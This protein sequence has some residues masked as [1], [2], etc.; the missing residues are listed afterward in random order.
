[1]P[2]RFLF[3]GIFIFDSHDSVPDHSDNEIKVW[4]KSLEEMSIE[5]E[6]GYYDQ[7]C[8]RVSFLVLY[9]ALRSHESFEDA[10]YTLKSDLAEIIQRNSDLIF[11]TR[12][13]YERSEAMFAGYNQ[14]LIRNL[15]QP[16]EMQSLSI[17][18]RSALFAYVRKTARKEGVPIRRVYRQ[19]VDVLERCESKKIENKARATVR[20]CYDVI[21]RCHA[22]TVLAQQ[23]REN[24][25]AAPEESKQEM[26]VLSL[27]AVSVEQV[28]HTSPLSG[29][30]SAF[31]KFQKP[32][33]SPVSHAVLG[34]NQNQINCLT[35]STTDS[36]LKATAT[37]FQ[38]GKSSQPWYSSQNR[39]N[40]EPAPAYVRH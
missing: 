7:L 2:E 6:A 39:E 18:G 8:S 34:S 33:D 20:S 28:Q 5:E 25:V 37:E 23:R 16:E 3:H 22:K 14:F 26:P 35:L 29:G 27:S 13:Q 15:C 32:A 19:M 30:K 10:V 9:Y 38:P 17:K 12:Y 24:A 31:S 36:K 21:R 1:M 11:Y 40:K 4:V